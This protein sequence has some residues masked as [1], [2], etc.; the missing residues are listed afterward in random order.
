MLYGE[1]G[2]FLLKRLI[3]VRMVMFWASIVNGDQRKLSAI[4]LKLM[5]RMFIAG[6]G[7]IDDKPIFAW[8]N[9]V[10]NILDE[11]GLSYLFWAQKGEFRSEW[12]KR[13]LNSRTS[14]I[15][16]Q[17]WSAEVYANK[18]CL[19]YRLFKFTHEFEGFMLTLVPS[20]RIVL[21]KFRCGSHM[22]P[23]MKARFNSDP[24]QKYCSLCPPC[25][26]I[27]DR[28]RRELYSYWDA[29][30][31]WYP[32]G[33]V[34]PLASVGDEYHYL[35]ECSYFSGDR[36][37]FLESKYFCRPN[38]LKFRQLMNVRKIGALVRLAKFV[39]ILLLH[40]QNS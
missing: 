10:K 39:R 9:R 24:S 7:S 11:N 14:D 12:L 1:T 8:F 38:A 15:Y 22:F 33:S 34:V 40:F 16:K 13:I 3:D 18:N 31:E 17:L 37:N 23:I 28:R 26:A 20:L 5:R 32:I 21:S 36:C 4:F 35:L 6:R 27:G 29:E 2:T 19:N 25:S 30:S